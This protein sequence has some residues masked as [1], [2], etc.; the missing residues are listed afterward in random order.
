VFGNKRIRLFL[1][2]LLQLEQKT[3]IIYEP[4]VSPFRNPDIVLF[5]QV[6]LNLLLPNHLPLLKI[7]S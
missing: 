3:L 6:V 4:F 5:I 7:F 1:N 2:R